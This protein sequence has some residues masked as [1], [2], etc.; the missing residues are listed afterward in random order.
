MKP[1]PTRNAYSGRWPLG[2]RVV[3][4]GREWRVV[5]R[6]PLR[7]GGFATSYQAT[8]RAAQRLKKA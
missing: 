1:N 3:W 2:F 4:N 5:A 7:L 6:R 8:K